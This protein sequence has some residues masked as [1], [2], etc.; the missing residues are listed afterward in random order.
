MYYNNT[1]A[2]GTEGSVP[3][4]NS[5]LVL[6]EGGVRSVDSSLRNLNQ[7]NSMECFSREV[8]ESEKSDLGTSGKCSVSLAS[9][10]TLN[11]IEDWLDITT[12]IYEPTRLK[13]CEKCGNYFE[14]SCKSCLSK[15][16]IVNFKKTKTALN[17]MAKKYNIVKREYALRFG[18]ERKMLLNKI[19]SH[20]KI[21][22]NSNWYL[23]IEGKP[24]QNVEKAVHDKIH[25]G[26]T[27]EFRVGLPGGAK[28]TQTQYDLFLSLDW[29][30]QQTLLKLQKGFVIHLEKFYFICGAKV[31]DDP[32]FLAY[33]TLQGYYCQ[34]YPRLLG[35]MKRNKPKTHA[36]GQTKK[37]TKEKTYQGKSTLKE[38]LTTYVKTIPQS[39]LPS[40]LITVKRQEFEEEMLYISPQPIYSDDP[41]W[42]HAYINEV[43]VMLQEFRRDMRLM[44]KSVNCWDTIQGKTIIP[45]AQQNTNNVCT[46]PA[47]DYFIWY[48][49]FA[50]RCDDGSFAWYFEEDSTVLY[51]KLDNSIH[52]IDFKGFRLVA[53]GKQFARGLR[54][55]RCVAD[56]GMWDQAPKMY[57]LGIEDLVVHRDVYWKALSIAQSKPMNT[58]SK[59]IFVSAISDFYTK[60]VHFAYAGEPLAPKEIDLLYTLVQREIITSKKLLLRN[61]VPLL[62]EQQEV[63]KVYLDPPP[64]SPETSLIMNLL[65]FVLP[66]P[67]FQY[68]K[69]K[70]A[71]F[72]IAEKLKETW[73]SVISKI[74]ELF[75][76]S[77]PFHAFP[78]LK[79][80]YSVILEELIK[81]IPGGGIWVA[82]KEIQADLR[83]GSFTFPKMLKRLAFH[84]FHELVPFKTIYRIVSFPIRVFLHYKYNKLVQEKLIPE[85]KF[86]DIW[87]E[88]DSKGKLDRFAEINISVPLTVMEVERFITTQDVE[89]HKEVQL[90]KMLYQYA[91]QA[92]YSRSGKDSY[93]YAMNKFA[94]GTGFPAK[95]SWNLLQF[96]KKRQYQG[97]PRQK[98]LNIHVKADYQFVQKKLLQ[99]MPRKFVSYTDWSS[100][101]DK[102]HLYDNAMKQINGNYHNVKYGWE[103]QIKTNELLPKDMGRTYYSTD[104]TYT[105]MT[106]PMIYELQTAMKNSLFSGFVDWGSIF[107]TGFRFYVLYASTGA[108]EIEDFFSRALAD[109]DAFYL[110]VV[111]DD[112][113]GIVQLYV[114]SM[115]MS[116]FDSTQN[117]F[118]QDWFKGWLNKEQ[119][120]GEYKVYLKQQDA[121]IKAR[122]PECNRYVDLPHVPGL[123]TGCMETSVSNT[124]L[125]SVT[126][127]IALWRKSEEQPWNEAILDFTENEAGFLPKQNFSK[128]E[129][130]F[131]FL[132]KG[133][134]VTRTDGPP[135][136]ACVPLLSNFS[137][138]G[139]CEKHP[140]HI[141]PFGFLKSDMQLSIDFDYMMLN[142]MFTKDSNFFVHQL[143]TEYEKRIMVSK[144]AVFEDDPYKLNAKGAHKVSR[145]E[146]LRFW[147]E[148]Y[149]IDQGHLNNL[150]SDLLNWDRPRIMTSDV[151]LKIV[152]VDYGRE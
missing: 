109:P 50:H 12:Q 135:K 75:I 147:F 142:S 119:Y 48:P 20:L 23:L 6:V 27:V 126:I 35:G 56:D 120:E 87:P 88:E 151:M 26:H 3:E 86:S 102:K 98:E 110:A 95:N 44:M 41:H 116:R 99:A 137:K 107:D 46:Q 83:N 36:P 121:P 84:N 145:L 101:S 70:L 92:L 10:C 85:V 15:N 40:K 111:G 54:Q 53:Q 78:A 96:M 133:W 82:A 128:L 67:L 77:F 73:N 74:S 57:D 103:L 90:P 94:V 43:E 138:L 132:K 118:F 11:E 76:G 130:G 124:L 8:S 9:N 45:C 65:R 60:S 62:S 38:S 148:R 79:V 18:K 19:H 144:S 122:I 149:Q 63:Q 106:G 112:S 117:S 146:L 32:F 39:D 68:L 71:T 108:P 105:V 131:E 47:H 37:K 52:K 31:L 51:L 89:I 49:D 150:L 55:Y 1:L 5:R 140:K 143:F 61:D 80:E 152:D 139:K 91:E 72:T 93:T 59:S 114:L 115:D 21:Q 134:I 14:I 7:V 17:K 125:M 66:Q 136:I 33:Y 42:K 25:Y 2:N 58:F 64:K 81:T 29:Q 30:H 16:R 127:F 4:N 28:T 22:P 113:S 141:I 13:L 69:D 123:K 24:S 97:L 129:D 100:K 104:P 34:R